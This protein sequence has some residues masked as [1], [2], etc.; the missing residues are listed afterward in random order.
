MTEPDFQFLFSLSL[1]AKF[2]WIH[3]ILLLK[4]RTLPKKVKFTSGDFIFLFSASLTFEMRLQKLNQI[5]G[6]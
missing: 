4:R 5:S 3:L 1:T 2:S 6:V